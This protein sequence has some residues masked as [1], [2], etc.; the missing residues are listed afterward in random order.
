MFTLAVDVPNSTLSG[1]AVLESLFWLS[2]HHG[3]LN[4]LKQRAL[5]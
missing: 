1:N 3:K 4:R 5:G 2:F